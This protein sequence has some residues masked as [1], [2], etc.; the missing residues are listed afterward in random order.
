MAASQEHGVLWSVVVGPWAHLFQRIAKKIESALLSMS[1]LGRIAWRAPLILKNKDLT[2]QQAIAIGVSSL[3]LLV[4]TSIFTGAVATF[5]VAY[6]FRNFV[7]DKFIGTAAA[8]MILIELGPVL[9]GLVL[10]G[11]VGSALAAELGSMKE[12]EEL[13]AMVVLDLDPL[14]YI[15]LPRFAAFILMMP[16]LTVISN[17]L[18]IFGGWIVAVLSLN[19][20]SYTFLSGLQLYFKPIDLY[21]GMFKSFVFGIII[22]LMG[23]VHGTTAGSGARGVGYAVMNS[24]VSASV[25]ILISDFVIAVCFF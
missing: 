4:I 25:L 23:Y 16:V 19:M 15:A 22:C 11:R 12:K 1:L 10:A 21:S 18:A 6:Q 14:R 17:L 8:K 20:T 5:Q 13:D 7:P 2:M 24:V 9:T 3:P